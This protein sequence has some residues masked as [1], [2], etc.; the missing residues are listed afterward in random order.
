RLESEVE[1]VKA[2]PAQIRELLDMR[3]ELDSDTGMPLEE[4]LS[5]VARLEAEA[6]SLDRDIGMLERKVKAGN[7]TRENLNR[8]ITALEKER[9]VRTSDAEEAARE[10]GEGG[11]ARVKREEVGRWYKVSGEVLDMVVG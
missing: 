9:Q 3:K 8:N 1:M 11:R 2:T 10:M 5:E 7:R 6:G 4:T